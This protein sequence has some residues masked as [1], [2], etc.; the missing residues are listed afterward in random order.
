MWGKNAGVFEAPLV[1]ALRLVRGGKQMR[2]EHRIPNGAWILYYYYSRNTRF[3][4]APVGR[5]VQ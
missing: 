4:E 2:P 3:C 1:F 5:P